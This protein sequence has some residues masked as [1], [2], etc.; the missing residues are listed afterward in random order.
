[1]QFQVNAAGNKKGLTDLRGGSTPH[2]FGRRYG[3]P[4]QSI[5]N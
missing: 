1:M 3:V 4:I 5:E 2:K